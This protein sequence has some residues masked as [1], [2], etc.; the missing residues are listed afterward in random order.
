MK[1]V[2]DNNYSKITDVTTKGNR[3][4][5][6]TSIDDELAVRS[7]GYFFSPAFKSGRWD[8]FIRFYD[9]RTRT[10]PTGLLDSVLSIFAEAGIEFEIDDNRTVYEFDFPEEIKLMEPSVEEGYITLRDYQYEAVV[11]TLKKRRGVVNV[12]TNGGKTEIASGIIQQLLPKMK[13]KQR[14]LFVTHNK[15][16]FH[17][18]AARIE[19]RLGIKVGKVGDGIWDLRPVTLVMIPTISRYVT[20]SKSKKKSKPITYTGEMKAIKRIFDVI[21][22]D[23]PRGKELDKLVSLFQGEN[24]RDA[25]EAAEILYNVREKKTTFKK[26]RKALEKYESKKRGKSDEKKQEVLD[27]LES[28]V[29][30]IGDEFHHSVSDTWYQSLMLCKNAVF[31]IGLTGTVDKKDELN[32]MR[33]LSCTGEITTK[34][35]NEFLISRGFSAKPTIHLSKIETPVIPEQ[36]GWQEAYR[37]GITEN[38]YRNKVIANKVASKYKEGKGCL[39]ITNHI[40]HG[41]TILDLLKEL[42]VEAEFTNGQRSSEDREAFLQR[43]RDGELR[44]LI[45]T[46]ILDEG[47]DISGINCVWMAAGG[48][49]YRQTLQRVGRG[50]RKKEDGSGLEVYDFLDFTHSILTKHTQERYTY[51]KDE[52]FEIKRDN[53]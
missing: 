35:S 29:C 8:G 19:K 43:M 15:E 4:L 9:R 12:A 47:V 33:I 1:I 2:V 16:I 26:L 3:D 37:I 28:A 49:S 51:Y 5:L 30:F 27:L 25:Q 45:A 31:R 17:Q 41:Q 18:S 7:P 6:L 21:E 48:K 39:I 32:Y 42:D 24:S 10:F 50:L 40:N 14:I 20:K 13:P 11:E 44:V 52:G 34:I 53:D 46:S 38:E 23:E 36:V 22:D